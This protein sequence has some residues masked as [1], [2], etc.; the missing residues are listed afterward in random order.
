MS[1]LKHAFENKKAFIPFITAGDP[2]LKVT[3][4]LVIKMADA[5]ADLIELGIPFSDPVAEG[6]VIQEADYRALEGGTTTDKIFD[7][8]SD[9]R[10]SCDVPLAFMTYANPVFTYGTDKFM[11]KCKEVDVSAVII[12]DIPFEEKKEIIPFSSKYGVDFISMIAPT[13]Q[14]RIRTISR[15]AQGFLY[16]V[17]SMG[18]TGVRQDIGS[19]VG[20]MIK[21]AKQVNDIPCA[22]GFGISDPEQAAKMSK[23]SD[24]V[25][26][27]SAIVKIIGKYGENCVPYVLDYVRTMKEAIV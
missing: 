21:A 7:M 1:K 8:I 17:S 12:P 10:K 15:E 16:C 19:E 27:G 9:V 23:I 11:K 6:P 2:T 3:E 24:G 26:V 5:G 20:E 22:I 13:S 18:V 14:S 25:I 4:E